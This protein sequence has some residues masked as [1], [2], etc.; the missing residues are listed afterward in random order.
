VPKPAPGTLPKTVA[1]PAG[2][3]ADEPALIERNDREVV[4]A[5]D[6]TGSEHQVIVVRVQTEAAVK[7]LSVVG[8]NFASA[9]QHVDID[10]VRVRHPDGTVVETTVA[11][12]L[13]MPTEV[14]R[15]APFY[16][17]LKQKQV[18]VRGLRA[19][20]RLEW[21]VHLIHT[22]AE[23][24]NRFWGIT[25][26]TGPERVALAESFTLR[27]PANVP[28]NVWSPKQK[29]AI[30]EEGGQRVYR[31]T[32][33]QLQPTVG[34]VA[35]ARAEAEKKRTLT[36][37]EVTDR[38]DG[39]LP[40]IAY[41]NFPDWASIG[42]WY[43]GL[44]GDRVAPDATI[45]AKAAE[46]IAGKTTDEDKIRALYAYTATE[47]RYIG[48]AL[49]QGRYQP[50]LASE[51]LSNQYG[52][53]K[54][55][56]T[57]LASLLA[58]AGYTA[59]TVLIGPGIR[60]NEAVP[61][62]A[63]FDHAITAVT[64][65]SGPNGQLAQRTIWLDS[66]QEVAP[67]RALLSVERDKQVLRI[68]LAGEA[69]LDRTPANLPF[70]S[71]DHF[72]ADGTLDAKG[73]AKGK[74]TY[75]FRGDDEIAVR[76]ALR[77]VSPA[78]YNDFAQY[79]LSSMGFGGKVTNATFTPPEQTDKP[80]LMTFD[81]ER[82]K[83]GGDW[84]NYRI[85]ALDAPDGLPT[86]DEKAPPQIPI[87]LGT[88]RTM[89]S[90][91]KLLLPAGWGAT[92]P[93][94]IH[95]KTPWLSYDRAYRFE[96]GALSEERTI[97]I[98]Q[99]R[100]PVA[101][102]HEYKSLTDAV[103]P[104]TYP[105]IQ[106]TRTKAAA[107]DTTPGPPLATKNN[108]EARL[109][110]VDAANANKVRQTERS[111]KLAMQAKA[112]NDEQPYLWSILGYNAFLRGETTEAVTDYTRELT[113]HPNEGNIYGLL[114]NAQLAQGKRD[115]AEATLRRRL[116]AVGPDANTS[117]TIAAMLLE[118]E[119]PAEALK[120]AEAASS[121]DPSNLRMRLLLGNTQMKSGDKAAGIATLTAALAAADT[122][123]LRNDIAYNL[124]DNGVAT[125]AVEA[126]SRKVVDDL[127]A[128]SATWQLTAADQDVKQMTAATQLLV[129]AWDTLGW[130]IYRNATGH[131]P[132][133]LAE[134]ERYVQAA[135]LA[136]PRAEVG[137]HLGEIQEMAGH[138]AEALA[139]YQLA[140]ATISNV[141]LRGVRRPPTAQQRELTARIARLQT[142][143]AGPA[144]KDAGKQLQAMRT[145]SLGTFSGSSRRL[146][147]RILLTADGS[148]AGMQQIATGNSGTTPAADSSQPTP[149]S[150]ESSARLKSAHF[151]TWLQHDSTAKMLRNAYVDCHQ[152]VCEAVVLPLG[153]TQ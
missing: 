145:F 38:E 65:G 136:D 104:G 99:Q 112:L 149:E 97:V 29:P 36:P 56:A 111:T 102:W 72:T 71:A 144:L 143:K 115:D 21:S 51:V 125:A 55:K 90:T 76:A 74:L 45:K 103:S 50:H 59:D 33:S 67:Y 26:F 123:L 41:T 70:A 88:P 84:D 47:I 122:P 10:Y 138:L 13:E 4:Y 87:D 15:Q 108:E 150:K 68:P 25:D 129:A 118:D 62:P 119:K 64:L 137:Q 2:K 148:V 9:S 85:V 142:A 132:S 130:T 127:T 93:E 117:G 54:D 39:Q 30:T 81:Y 53:C 42:A 89:T 40:Q 135:W 152:N 80:M 134:A 73:T 34:P 141:D 12:A 28:A 120:V 32:S 69:H 110:L 147:F 86:F 100:I 113:L 11:D 57:L 20:D 94:A 151:N 46:L 79:L 78:Q 1:N 82:E 37:E 140:A 6:G 16:S 22:R 116:S 105:Y 83:P 58:A 106:L 19:G 48:V 43:R 109:L 24:P 66:T 101:K 75:S 27:L 31:W 63:A 153:S 91:S 126:V 44:E 146:L 77:Q 124:A 52:D 133:R 121:A 49:G 23:A 14:M 139:T 7:Q 96:N 8:F 3:Y 17:D 61:S 5:A 18:P 92:L 98:L 114:A 128:E 95:Q 60:F 131:D 35:T 107:G